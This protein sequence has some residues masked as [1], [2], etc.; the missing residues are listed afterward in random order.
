MK[1]LNTL[2]FSL[3]VGVGCIICSCVEASAGGQGAHGVE[4][5]CAAS[6]AHGNMEFGLSGILMGET[7]GRN[8]TSYIWT[9]CPQ[10]EGFDVIFRND[11]PSE[12]LMLVPGSGSE[13][14][15]SSTAIRGKKLYWRTGSSEGVAELS[16]DPLQM[17]PIGVIDT[18][19][20]VVLCSIETV[21]ISPE[22]LQ[23]DFIWI[24]WDPA[25]KTENAR[26]SMSASERDNMIDVFRGFVQLGP[27]HMILPMRS[28]ENFGQTEF[29]FC[30]ID[31]FEITEVVTMDGRVRRVASLPQGE[32]S[33]VLERQQ[34]LEGYVASVGP[35]PE[36]RLHIE[37][38]VRTES[39]HDELNFWD[40]RG[41]REFMV[42]ADAPSILQI[43]DVGSIELDM[44]LNYVTIAP[45]GDQIALT[46]DRRFQIWD[47]PT[48][49]TP[50]KR[51]DAVMVENDG[52]LAFV[53]YVEE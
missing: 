46:D 35:M 29:I 6:L 42:R 5:C 50:T 3:C 10:T 8:R 1:A 26:I 40:F 52:E 15:A 12:R 49:G 13:C 23:T 34:G 30:S 9:Y 27:N 43:S 41:E 33:F 51:L 2:T 21:I 18:N 48:A 53:P 37:A 7:S 20:A 22:E 16:E 4:P 14:F 44:K 38:S 39:D 32:A 19:C 47:I 11:V 17:R 31:P 24:L 25:A 45:S 36:G 28:G